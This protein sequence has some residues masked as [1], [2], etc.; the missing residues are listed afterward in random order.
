MLK[1]GDLAPDFPVGPTT[2]H[3]LLEDRP[4]VVFFFPKAFTPGCTKEAGGF[5]EEY[6]RL[7][8]G[9][10][11]VIGVS[12]DTQETSDRFRAELGLPYPLVGDAKGQIIAAWGVKIPLLGVARRVTFVVGRDRRVE[13]VY[14]S[15]FDAMSHVD[16][17]CR[18]ALG[19]A[20]S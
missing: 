5:R 17:A 18:N 12:K 14:E 19:P 7:T 2:L 20:K 11:E 13:S 9:K 1:V 4:V 8:A 6:D 10:V 3:R 15:Q 16:V